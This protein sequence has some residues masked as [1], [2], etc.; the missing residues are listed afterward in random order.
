MRIREAAARLG[1][2]SAFLR[3]REREGLLPAP[4]RNYVGHRWYEPEDIE[5]IR[6]I[7]CPD[8]PPTPR[9]WGRPGKEP[10]KAG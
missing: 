2:S 7:L 9:G 8:A 3:R 10:T 5:A 1:V 4:R 6:R